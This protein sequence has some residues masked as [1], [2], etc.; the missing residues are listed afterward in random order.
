LFGI[1]WGSLPVYLLEEFEDKKNPA[2]DVAE[3]TII[4]N[5]LAKSGYKKGY[6]KIKMLK[7]PS[8]FWLHAT[9]Q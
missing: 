4:Y 8:H 6:M 9:I 1:V 3:L 5:G 7:I 2:S